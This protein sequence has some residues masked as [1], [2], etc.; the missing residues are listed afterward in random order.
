MLLLLYNVYLHKVFKQKVTKSFVRKQIFSLKT[1]CQV[2]I[3][4]WSSTNGALGW[5]KLGFKESKW[6]FLLKKKKGR[7]GDWCSKLQDVPRVWWCFRAVPFSSKSPTS[8]SKS[9]VNSR[10][11]SFTQISTD[12][13][14]SKHCVTSHDIKQWQLLGR[15]HLGISALQNES[16]SEDSKT[17]KEETL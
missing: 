6:N 1:R 5:C 15:S 17:L 2:S 14:T 9:F 3:A 13:G 16:P 8:V 12:T 7:E 10:N 11:L 4:P